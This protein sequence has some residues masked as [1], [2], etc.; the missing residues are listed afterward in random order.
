MV[1]EVPGHRS[2]GDVD[3]LLLLWTLHQN[4]GSVSGCKMYME[5]NADGE[6]WAPHVCHEKWVP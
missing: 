4:I 5:M 6:M 1:M 2:L 3:H